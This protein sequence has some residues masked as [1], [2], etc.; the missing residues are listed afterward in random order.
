M[1]G[2]AK[3]RQGRQGGQWQQNDRKSEDRRRDQDQRMAQGLHSL[4]IAAERRRRAAQRRYRR[5]AMQPWHGALNL[6]PDA[7]VEW[8]Q[9][10]KNRKRRQ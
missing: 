4:R 1:F 7:G 5:Q 10:K 3:Q 8:R 2:G 6:H 9:S